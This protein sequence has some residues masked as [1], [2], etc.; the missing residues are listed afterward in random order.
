MNSRLVFALAAVWLLL[1]AGCGKEVNVQSQISDLENAFPGVA[2][3]APASL[4]AARRPGSGDPRAFVSAALAASRTNDWATAVI[5]I[6]AALQA[7][8]TTP[9]QA[10]ALQA[11]RKTWVTDLMIRADQ[12][13]V[14][15]KAA[16][17][18]IERSH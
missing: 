14:R 7:P 2:A 3:V 8:G 10:M 5:M 15:A 1:G 6:E 11:T 9:Q 18:L 12:G 13:D 17:V 16:L 4:T